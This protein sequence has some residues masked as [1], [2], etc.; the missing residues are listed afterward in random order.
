MDL[1]EMFDEVEKEEQDATVVSHQVVISPTFVKEKEPS[2]LNEKE[3]IQTKKQETFGKNEC[4]SKQFFDWDVSPKRM[5]KQQSK[6]K[7]STK[8][9]RGAKEEKLST[10]KPK[11]LEKIAKLHSELANAKKNGL[12]VQQRKQLRN[13][14]QAQYQRLQKREQF[15]NFYNTIDSHNDKVSVFL[16]EVLQKRLSPELMSSIVDDLPEA[17]T[18]K[19][20]FHKTE[21]KT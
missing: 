14:A 17:W 19:S 21:D 11:V 13:K 20:K 12:S 7:S 2:D 1:F 3:T 6:Q 16:T 4:F 10:Y 18:S 15:A 8:L 5:I 9:H